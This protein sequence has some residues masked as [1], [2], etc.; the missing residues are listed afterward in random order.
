MARDG[1]DAAVVPDP[2]RPGVQFPRMLTLTQVKEILNV[3]MPTIYALLA[4]Q[5]LRGV[6]LGGSVCGGSVKTIS[7]RTWNVPTKKR[8]T[9]S[10]PAPWR[11][12]PAGT[13]TKRTTVQ[14]F[15]EAPSAAFVRWQ[16]LTDQG[17]P[18]APRIVTWVSARM[19]SRHSKR[20]PRTLALTAPGSARSGGWRAGTRTSFPAPRR[21]LPKPV[22]HPG[23]A[24]R[25]AG[26]LNAN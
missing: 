13:G 26:R 5:D 20:P 21:P 12:G 19:P 7:P 1:D 23:D 6:Q 22:Q 8:R 24:P 16:R 15:L 25:W 14:P 11:P 3:G 4:S 18:T 17:P 9:V 2:E 10:P